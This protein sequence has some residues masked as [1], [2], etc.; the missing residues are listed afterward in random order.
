MVPIMQDMLSP[1]IQDTISVAV[2]TATDNIKTKVLDKMVESN[3]EL[4]R[5]V[6]EQTGIINSQK[7]LINE[8]SE[9]IDDQTKVLKSKS[10]KIGQLEMD[11]ELLILEIDS[12]KDA[13]NNL[14]QYGRRNS[15]RIHNFKPDHPS[16]DE[17]D[18]SDM[19]R[20][21][22]NTTILR[23][24]RPLDIRDIERCH[25]VGRTKEGRP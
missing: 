8:Q 11:V 7:A 23:E 15:I 1:L 14:E 16:E 4:Q 22:L 3:E 19:V 25:Y 10:S 9:Q 21:F 24:T 5:F 2:S 13:L 6:T 18:M 17:Y 12:W 20:N